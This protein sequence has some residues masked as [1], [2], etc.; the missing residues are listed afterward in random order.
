MSYDDNETEAF[1]TKLKTYMAIGGLMLSGIYHHFATETRMITGAELQN[2]EEKTYYQCSGSGK[3]RHCHWEHDYYY[4]LKNGLTLR[5]ESSIWDGK[6]GDGQFYSKVDTLH[7]YDFK[8]NHDKLLGGDN[9][10]DITQAVPKT[11]A[12]AYHPSMDST[13]PPEE[14]RLA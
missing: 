9:V 5:D 8:T 14:L 7:I 6:F 10:L 4:Y 13:I 12:T 11:A 3:N 1:K 2:K